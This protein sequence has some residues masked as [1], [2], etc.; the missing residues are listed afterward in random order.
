MTGIKMKC[1]TSLCFICVLLLSHSMGYA[2]TSNSS[3]NATY[4]TPQVVYENSVA[5]PPITN[6]SG[7]LPGAAQPSASFGLPGQPS[8]TQAVLPGNAST[9]TGPTLLQQ[10]YQQPALPNVPSQP[11]AQAPA[12]FAYQATPFESIAPPDSYLPG[13]ATINEKKWMV[14]DYLYN[15]SSNIGIKVD[16]LK[17]EKKYIP[18]SSDMLQKRVAGVFEEAKINTN[19][20][21]VNCQPPLPMFY[22][23][24]MV[25]PCEKRCVGF[26][27]A[28]LYEIAKP[29]RVDLELNGVWQT[30][31]WE[32]QA[33]V[34]SAWDDFAE[35]VAKALEEI[36]S[37]FTSKYTYYHPPLER[38]CYPVSPYAR[39]E[40][41]YKKY[42]EKRNECCK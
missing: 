13:L 1:I 40:E 42:Y 30:V 3:I 10:T 6:P 37:A 21:L 29:E 27:T 36:A 23:L 41:L 24:V 9:P 25:Y 5:V 17:P 12:P 31:T 7:A 19:A 26:V 28:Q 32:R 8:P 11:G 35:E 14:S 33:L 4:N 34:A 38:P 22:V 18:L 20:L 39:T 15:L 16:V 2:Q